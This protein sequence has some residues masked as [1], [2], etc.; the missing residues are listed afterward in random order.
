MHIEDTIDN[1][2]NFVQTN[3][4]YKHP[5]SK[6]EVEKLAKEETK[7]FRDIIDGIVIAGSGY[8]I[9]AFLKSNPEL[10]KHLVEIT[11]SVLTKSRDLSAATAKKFYKALKLLGQLFMTIPAKPR[12]KPNPFID[13]ATW[14]YH[15]VGETVVRW[16]W[17]AGLTSND[18]K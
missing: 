6:K 1:I 9:Y 7:L 15:S 18:K 16:K 10:S 4:Y 5:M 12:A 8:A 17:A 3:R 13:F 11:K 2:D 14:F